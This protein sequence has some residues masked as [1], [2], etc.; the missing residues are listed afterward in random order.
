LRLTQK[1][2]LIV[3]TEIDAAFAVHEEAKSHA[4]MN[5]KLGEGT[6][7]ARS[8]KIKNVVKRSTAAKLVS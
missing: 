5:L 7:D 2:G 8:S 4:G 6:L 3:S 1:N